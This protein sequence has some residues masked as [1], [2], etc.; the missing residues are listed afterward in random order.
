MFPHEA[1][2]RRDAIGSDDLCGNLFLLHRAVEKCEAVS[3]INPLP[4]RPP[5]F[6]YVPVA[7]Y[8]FPDY[9]LAPLSPSRSL[10]KQLVPGVR[11]ALRSTQINSEQSYGY[12]YS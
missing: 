10:E 12:G 3:T 2:R 1:I 5:R 7:C 11:A 4:Q 9:L 6:A 8:F